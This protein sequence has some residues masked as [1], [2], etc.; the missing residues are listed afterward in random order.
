MRRVD[1][2]EWSYCA[3]G[4]ALQP[5]R[6]LADMKPERFPS[7][8]MALES[9]MQ[10]NSITGE[11][12][13]DPRFVIRFEADADQV[14]TWIVNM[15]NHSIAEVASFNRKD[16][17]R[18]GIRLHEYFRTRSPKALEHFLSLLIENYQYKVS[19]LAG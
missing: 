3:S 19:Y 5:P 18:Y 15:K 8:R 13:F 14:L 6:S 10:I 11:I 1:G 16:S 9:A 12:S 2:A 17:G 4:I 7:Q